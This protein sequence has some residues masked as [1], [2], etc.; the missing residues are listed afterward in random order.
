MEKT[1]N[2]Y[3][4]PCLANKKEASL[5]IDPNQLYIEYP[6]GSVRL[7]RLVPLE[8][9]ENKEALA[10]KDIERIIDLLDDDEYIGDKVSAKVMAEIRKEITG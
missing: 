2:G 7:T 4:I 1:E 8:M 3:K 5:V 6:N 10:N 9:L